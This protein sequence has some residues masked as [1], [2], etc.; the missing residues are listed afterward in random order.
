MYHIRLTILAKAND[1]ISHRRTEAE[2]RQFALAL[3]ISIDRFLTIQY[4]GAGIL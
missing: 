3:R 2:S 1:G 4:L